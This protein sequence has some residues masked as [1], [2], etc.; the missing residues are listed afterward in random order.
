MLSVPMA[1]V[2]VTTLDVPVTAFP[3]GRAAD[4][5]GDRIRGDAGV[6]L[7]LRNTGSQTVTARL[8]GQRPCNLGQLHDVVVELAPGD[9]RFATLA[10]PALHDADGF[11]QLRYSPNPPAGLVVAAAHTPAL[12]AV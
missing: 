11:V 7:I 9:A 6:F 4:A 10:N 8:L 2:P 5:D 3:A 12:G 1:D